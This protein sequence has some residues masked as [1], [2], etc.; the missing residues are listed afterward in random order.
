[1]NPCAKPSATPLARSSANNTYTVWAFAVLKNHLHLCI[2]RHRD[3]AQVDAGAIGVGHC[4]GVSTAR[5][6]SLPDH[7]IWADRPYK[8]F[9]Y[10][11]EAV[12]RVIA[13]IERNPIK[14]GLGP[15]KWPF[16]VPYDG[17]PF[18]KRRAR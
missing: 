8:K 5:P 3:S 15:Q 12:R 18:H 9:L 7:P 11:P 1:M 13:Y 6:G 10:T 2:R 14:E 16:V 17:W 4:R